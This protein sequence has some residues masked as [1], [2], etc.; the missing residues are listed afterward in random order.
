MLRILRAF[1]WMRWRMLINS[2]EK[3]GSRDTLERFSIAAEKLGP[4]IATLLLVPTSLVLAGVGIA[5]GYAL[6]SGDGESV[7]IAAA[8]YLL[9]FV[10]VLAIVGPLVLPA[11]DRANPVRLLL[12]PIPPST[13]Y[14]AQS[15]VAF[16]DI[17]NLLMLPLVI[18][19]PIGIA[20]AGGWVAA[21]A[22]LTAS[23]LLVLVVVGVASVATS[24]LALIVR[25]RRRGEL[26]A[27]IFIIVLP[28]VSMLPGILSAGSRDRD[29]PRRPIAPM[30]LLENGRR[31]AAVYPT[32]LYL[33]VARGATAGQAPQSGAGLAGLAVTALALH[34]VGLLLFTRLLQQPGATGRRR[35]GSARA[36][37]GWTLPGLSPAASA[38]AIAQT[39]LA[40]RTPRGRSILLSPLAM[41]A[42]FGVL[43]YRGGGTMD[44]GSMKIQGGISLATF[45]TF[46]AMM[47]ILPIAMNQFAVDKAGL[48]L[49]LLSPL[50]TA[51]YLKGKAAGNALVAA[52]PT[53]LSLLV[54]ALLFPGGSWY[55]WLSLLLALPSI[56]FLTAPVAAVCSAV[57]PRAVDMNS[58][59]RG[60]NAHGAAGFIGLFAF[61]AAA[62]PPVLLTLLATALLDR[63]AIA[64][65]LVALWG[66]VAYTIG[67]LGFV[68]ARRIFDARKENLGLVI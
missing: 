40:L 13:L 21:L 36:A 26:L 14:V 67:R 31:A 25:D 19:I 62:V 1:A 65:V 12:L 50:T 53:L 4:I 52:A 42:I 59:G 9:I 34:G 55:L 56:F 60:S 5:A 15:S 24:A 41:L 37:W 58:I 54:A 3:T 32:E 66:I 49:A 27:L 22:V 46:V 61:V 45:A 16:G 64:P 68:P 20:A 57:F 63:P 51:E 7:L 2:F 23:L 43:I 48:T 28:A 18:G 33:D 30:W 39:K 44:F 17:W 8:R 38:V 29:E 35:T 10:P 11:A 47:S 6:G